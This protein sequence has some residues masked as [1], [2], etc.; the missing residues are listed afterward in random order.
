[1]EMKA[2]D[3]KLSVAVKKNLK[4]RLVQ[5]FSNLYPTEG[6]P[7]LHM[8]VSFIRHTQIRGHA[9]SAAS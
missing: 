2:V 4:A 3:N 1:M 8:Y 6:P 7:A 9:V 5:W